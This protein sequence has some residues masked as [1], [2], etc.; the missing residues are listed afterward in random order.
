[1]ALLL[2][3]VAALAF[4]LGGVLRLVLEGKSKRVAAAGGW[5][6]LA[7]PAIAI[8]TL[9]LKRYG[10]SFWYLAPQW[11]FTPWV[12]VPLT[13]FYLLVPLRSAWR[14]AQIHRDEAIILEQAR[15][16]DVDA[17]EGLNYRALAD[18]IGVPPFPVLMSKDVSTAYA[19]GILSK[20][21]II[22]ASMVPVERRGEKD[23]YW[24]DIEDSPVSTEEMRAILAHELAHHKD[25]AG[26][27]GVLMELAGYL[28]PW[29]FVAGSST[30]YS[31][32]R[33]L[34]PG[35]RAGWVGRGLTQVSQ[36]LRVI[37]R[38]IWRGAMDAER[39]RQE[40]RA[41]D[42]AIRVYP[43]ARY[44][45]ESMRGFVHEEAPDGHSSFMQGTLLAAGLAV[46]GLGLIAL[47]GRAAW[48]RLAGGEAPIPWHLPEGWAVNEWNP[49]HG[50][51]A[52]G[53]FKARKGAPARIRVRYE[54]PGHGKNEFGM[55]AGWM[56]FPVKDG[57]RIP[58]AARVQVDW[59]VSYYGKGNPWRVGSASELQPVF[60]RL[61]LDRAPVAGLLLNRVNLIYDGTYRFEPAG[62]NRII[63]HLDWDQLPEAPLGASTLLLGFVLRADSPGTYDLETPVVRVVREDGTSYELREVEAGLFQDSGI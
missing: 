50:V 51:Q 33:N 28:Y 48:P 29:E 35:S 42:D 47:P 61:G 37:G 34:G 23:E 18:Q 2:L 7:F 38:F 6:L 40:R 53:F 43:P 15:V 19:I 12:S 8:A 4:A 3:L 32:Y 58:K 22:S 36:W 14:R 26:L 56:R 44:L 39:L 17:W 57:A 27:R 49:P 9:L 11:L 24:G 30:D 16:L 13:V 1:M 60:L 41:D 10:P 46:M 55:V 52:L 63:T 5:V 54:K 25:H 21:V 62:P 45:I 20:K 59:P 31:I